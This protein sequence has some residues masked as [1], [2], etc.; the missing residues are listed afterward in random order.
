MA[1]AN[2]FARDCPRNNTANKTEFHGTV[3]NRYKRFAN[4]NCST[5]VTRYGEPGHDKRDGN[6]SQDVAAY[7][8]IGPTDCAQAA[9]KCS[10]TRQ[11]PGDIRTHL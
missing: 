2:L 6:V 7:A 11:V 10:I 3:R 5:H 9:L 4:C 8:K 1:W